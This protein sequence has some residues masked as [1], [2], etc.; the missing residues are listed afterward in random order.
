VTCNNGLGPVITLAGRREAHRNDGLSIF[1][2]LGQALFR[3]TETGLP[4]HRC[5]EPVAR[6]PSA[7]ITNFQQALLTGPKVTNQHRHYCQRSYR[8]VSIP[9]LSSLLSSHRIVLGH[10]GTCQRLRHIRRQISIFILTFSHSINQFHTLAK[11]R[12]SFRRMYSRMQKAIPLRTRGQLPT[13]N[14]ARLPRVPK[15]LR[16]INFLDNQFTPLQA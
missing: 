16:I 7:G 4:N 6:M 1:K 11:I 5:G 3:A 2:K 12:A 14:T 10:L 15:R 9:P 13:P 8:Y